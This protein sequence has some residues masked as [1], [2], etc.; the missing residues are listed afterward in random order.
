MSRL[1]LITEP[2]PILHK[3]ASEIAEFGAT[4]VKLA[5][6][7]SETMVAENG[8]GLAAPQINKSL[9]FFVVATKNGA[10]KAFAN[11]EIYWRSIATNLDEE[12]CL[13]IPGVFGIVRR[14]NSIKIRYQDEYGNKHD[15]K[16]TGFIARVIQHEFDHIEGILITE[17]FEK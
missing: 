2:N 17:K 9:R 3:K 14:H 1:D 5:Q 13:S 16:Y 7:M 11:P 4:T 6:D 15:E 8:V 10:F 12:G